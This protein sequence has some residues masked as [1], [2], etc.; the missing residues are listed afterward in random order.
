[1]S[2]SKGLWEMV[3]R[4]CAWTTAIGALLGA[5]YGVVLLVT[6]ILSIGQSGPNGAELPIFIVILYGI[7]LAMFFG[8]I[9]AGVIGFI[10]GPIGGLLCGLMT[11]LFFTPLRSERAYR[12]TA[13][14]TGALYGLFSIVVAVRLVSTSGFAPPIETERQA[15]ILYLFPALIGGAGGV[16]ISRKMVDWYTRAV[17]PDTTATGEEPLGAS[18]PA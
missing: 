16:F 7:L 10:A 3:V 12:I 8:A 11:R 6:M 15:V 2:T 17:G 9:V 14:I 4:G 18:R 13:G 5:G 1:M